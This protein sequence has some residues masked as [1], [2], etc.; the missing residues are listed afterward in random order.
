M[1]RMNLE[2]FVT[3]NVTIPLYRRN[4]NTIVIVQYVAASILESYL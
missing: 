3:K 2:L 4:K 1:Y